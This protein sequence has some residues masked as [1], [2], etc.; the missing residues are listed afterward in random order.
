MIKIED[1]MEV[2]PESS[3]INYVTGNT[4]LRA[5]LHEDVVNEEDRESEDVS[6]PLN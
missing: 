6:L 4:N 2:E 1:T 5:A 3:F